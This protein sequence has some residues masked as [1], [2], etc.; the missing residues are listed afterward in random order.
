MSGCGACKRV[1]GRS[2]L[3]YDG[4]KESVILCTACDSGMYLLEFDDRTVQN[5]KAAASTDAY[6]LSLCVPRCEDIAYNYVSNPNTMR[7]EYCG[8][9]CTHCTLQYGCADCYGQRGRQHSSAKAYSDHVRGDTT[10][11]KTGVFP[12][13]YHSKTTYGGPSSE[14]RTCVDCKKL[15]PRCDVCENH[16]K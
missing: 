6:R 15:D 14:F 5:Q 11:A 1:T 2:F 7:C 10:K 8:E 12:F 13:R 9:T 16:S 3:E 4:R